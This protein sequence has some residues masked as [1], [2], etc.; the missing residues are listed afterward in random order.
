[1][2]VKALVEVYGCA[3]Q[4][5]C[6]IVG[7]SHSTFYYRPQPASDEHLVADLKKEA[8]QYPTYGSRRLRHQLRRPPYH[9]RVNRKRIQRLMRQENLLRPVKRAKCRTT[10]S[11]HAYPRYPNLVDG[12]AINHPEQVWV[13]DI[14]YIRL[15]NGFVYLAVVMDVF[16]RAVRGWSLSRTLDTGLTLAALRLALSLCIP[17]IHH[18]DQGVQYAAQEYV[19]LL[20][21]Y[22]VQISMTAQGKPEE[23]GYAERLMRTIKEEEVDLSEYNDFADARTQIGHFIEDVYMTKR[24]HSSLGYLTPVEFEVAWQLAQQAQTTP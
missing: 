10:N 18:S 1:M 5:A 6:E 14:T 3:V 9:Y 16:T 23:N 12:L 13:C 19:D 22:D 4:V 17:E 20:K 2:M 8:G 7:M 11:E 15:G 24:I 21:K